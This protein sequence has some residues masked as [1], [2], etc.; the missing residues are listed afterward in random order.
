MLL[1]ESIIRSYLTHIRSIY[2]FQRH[3]SNN[4]S[5]LDFFLSLECQFFQQL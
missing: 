3:L 4:A 5:L 1:V 2:S